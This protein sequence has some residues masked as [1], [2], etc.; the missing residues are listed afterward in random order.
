[1][2]N[3]FQ[4]LFSGD[5]S[6]S[7]ETGSKRPFNKNKVHLHS[8][9]SKLS[10]VDTAAVVA[11]S[12]SGHSDEPVLFR[13]SFR[14]PSVHAMHSLDLSR[15][16][17]H[18]FHSLHTSSISQESPSSSTAEAAQ[19]TPTHENDSSHFHNS[20]SPPDSNSTPPEE[21]VQTREKSPFQRDFLP[22]HEP[23]VSLEKSRPRRSNVRRSARL[24]QSVGKG[25]KVERPARNVLSTVPSYIEPDYDEEDTPSNFVSNR[26]DPNVPVS[27][28]NHT[29]E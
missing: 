2:G 4:R 5:S 28:S 8:S 3:F 22:S 29:S 25:D 9:K 20:T 26:A 23:L 16:E 6:K 11:T 15:D 18:S 14:S 19:V 12:D 21:Q 13:R 17:D 27:H 1:M 10:P 7:A 24:N